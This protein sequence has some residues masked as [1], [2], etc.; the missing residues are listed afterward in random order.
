MTTAPTTQTSSTYFGA[1][2]PLPFPLGFAIAHSD[3]TAALV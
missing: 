3:V 2:A 1:A